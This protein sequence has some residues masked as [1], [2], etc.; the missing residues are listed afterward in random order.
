MTSPPQKHMSFRIYEG[1]HAAIMSDDHQLLVLAIH[2][3]IPMYHDKKSRCGAGLAVYESSDRRYIQAL[4]YP[5]RPGHRPG[6]KDVASTTIASCFMKPTPEAGPG[7]LPAGR[8]QDHLSSERPCLSNSCGATP[9]PLGFDSKHSFA[10]GLLSGLQ[11]F[12]L[13]RRAIFPRQDILSGPAIL[14]TRQRNL[15]QGC[16]DTSLR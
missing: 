3:K 7:K 4:R 16:V 8:N 12:H 6:H 15:R 10:G 13:F 1:T 9:V 11:A 2:W 5:E 14:S